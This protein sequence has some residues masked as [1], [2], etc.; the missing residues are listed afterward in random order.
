MSKCNAQGY[1]LLATLIFLQI[2]SCISLYELLTASASLKI[3]TDYYYRNQL[4]VA[5]N[6][7]LAE[8]EKNLQSQRP[9]C[10]IANVS[11]ADVSNQVL[12][13]WK[14]IACRKV[15][16]DFSYFY[17]VE[18]L[19]SDPC[20]VFEKNTNNQQ[21]GADYYRITLLSENGMTRHIKLIL[22]STLAKPSDHALICATSSHPVYP[23]RQMVR[24]L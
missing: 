9:T 16:E 17:Y 20:A 8:L 14:F 2:A 1:V 12:S 21:I 13:W 15:S 3:T 24:E 5:A 18:F 11:A 22:Q 23:G 4:T 10:L 7:A 19:Q 6:S